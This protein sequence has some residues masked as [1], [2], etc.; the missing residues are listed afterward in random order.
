M[1]AQSAFLGPHKPEMGDRRRCE[2]CN[3]TFPS[4]E[5]LMKHLRDS[6]D[7]IYRIYDTWGDQYWEYQK[8]KATWF[9]ESQQEAK[10]LQEQ[11]AEWEYKG[12]EPQAA[13]KFLC[14][15]CGRDLKS[16]QGLDDHA[17][18]CGLN[19]E[20]AAAAW[21]RYKPFTC[22]RICHSG[23]TDP[24]PGC[25]DKGF[26]SQE[27]L[28]SHQE[29][30]GMDD[31]TRQA[32][33][34]M[35][36]EAYMATRRTCPW[37]QATNPNKSFA[38]IEALLQHQEVCGKSKDDLD[39]EW[40]AANTF[41]CRFCNHHFPRVSGKGGMENHINSHHYVELAAEVEAREQFLRRAAYLPNLQ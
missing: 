12:Y 34:A 28:V 8:Q 20:E 18:L 23:C 36:F 10:L 30:C 24:T 1:S 26:K 11:K 22:T 38:T 14:K 37:C 3:D 33:A 25:H 6:D 29:N 13:V 7:C 40:Y 5:W 19:V 41:V 39:R 32:G 27:A 2:C 9:R 16:A 4:T 15:P 35:K 21:K 31:P 17:W